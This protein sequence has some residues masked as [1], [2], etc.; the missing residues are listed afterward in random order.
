MRSDTVAVNIT[1]YSVTPRHLDISKLIQGSSNI[2]IFKRKSPVML[3]NHTKNLPFSCQQGVGS[4]LTA[5]TRNNSKNL[6]I[7]MNII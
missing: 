3:A 7:N 4:A 1:V 6:L 2:V 5:T